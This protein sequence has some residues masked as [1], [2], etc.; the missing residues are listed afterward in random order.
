VDEWY[1]IPYE[2]LGEKLTLHFSPSG[3]RQKY[4]KYREAWDLLKGGKISIQAC[5]DEV[6]WEETSHFVEN[7]NFVAVI[8]VE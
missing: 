4:G 6:E 5:A 1:I 3:G 7:E 8:G 2:A